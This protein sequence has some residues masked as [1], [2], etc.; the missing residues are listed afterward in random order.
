MMNPGGGKVS[1]GHDHGSMA[2]AETAETEDHSQHE[3]MEMETETISDI[4]HTSFTVAGNCDMC[5]DRIEEAAM[6]V[7]GVE[8]AEWDAESQL[9]HLNYKA[10]EAD[11]EDVQIA[12]ANSGHDTEDYIAPDEVYDELPGCCLYERLHN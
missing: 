1:T 6:S 2:S 3:T 8:S 4:A 7:D 10:S 9:L 5:K 12:I 11:P